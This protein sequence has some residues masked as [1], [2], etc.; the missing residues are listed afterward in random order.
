MSEFRPEELLPRS[1]QKELLVA[2]MEIL[3]D[4]GP[5]TVLGF[6]EALEDAERKF[7]FCEIL[8]VCRNLEHVVDLI[9]AC[10]YSDFEKVMRHGAWQRFAILPLQPVLSYEPFRDDEYLQSARESLAFTDKT[11]S[12]LIKIMLSSAKVEGSESTEWWA[13]VKDPAP[14]R[15]DWGP[16]F[17][18]SGYPKYFG[19][20]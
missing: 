8:G 9:K 20:S 14:V 5:E 1:R 11:L 18:L 3:D 12:S 19:E 6:L 4:G 17:W 16:L 13:R 15:P 10:A 2:F 7:V